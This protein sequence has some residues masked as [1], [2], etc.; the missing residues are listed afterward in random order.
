VGT[1]TQGGEPTGRAAGPQLS[2]CCTPLGIRGEP[3]TEQEE[4]DGGEP[5]RRRVDEQELCWGEDVQEKDGGARPGHHRQPVGEIEQPDHRAGL[6]RRDERG[7]QRMQVGPTHDAP[8]S[9]HQADAEH[10]TERQDLV[11]AERQHRDRQRAQEVEPDEGPEVGGGVEQAR[12]DGADE[13][14]RQGRGSSQRDREPQGTG[15]EQQP[16]NDHEQ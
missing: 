12:S 6:A 15:V 13:E 3:A 8:Q 11:D 16:K 5:E 1:A 7:H 9:Q 10:A 2:P 4:R 14:G